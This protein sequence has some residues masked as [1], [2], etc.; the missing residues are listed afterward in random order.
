MSTPAPQFPASNRWAGRVMLLAGVALAILAIGLFVIQ[1]GLQR[2]FVPW[3]VPIV[4]TLGVA[5]VG[6]SLVRRRS[7]TRFIML[8]LLAALAA[9][10]WQFL[11]FGALLPEYIGPARVGQKLPHFYTSRADGAMFRATDLEDG[12]PRVMTFFRGRW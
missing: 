7:A 4:T 11:T 3:Y 12:T 6:W 1:F 5:L 2:L 9:F 10:E 8:A